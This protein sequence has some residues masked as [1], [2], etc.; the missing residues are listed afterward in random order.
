MA[1]RA[2]VYVRCPHPVPAGITLADLGGEVAK[3][4]WPCS[5]DR[6]RAGSSRWCRRVMCVIAGAFGLEL[7]GGSHRPG[8][9]GA[10]LPGDGLG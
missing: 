1:A 4:P 9:E 6:T 2:L 7:A 5:P 8:A 10:Q 3:T